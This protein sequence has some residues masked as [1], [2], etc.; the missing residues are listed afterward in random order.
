MPALPYTIVDS[1]HQHC[2]NNLGEIPLPNPGQPFFGQDGNFQGHPL[3]YTMSADGLTALDNQTGL[4]WQ[5]VPETNL[6]GKLTPDEY[7]PQFG[8]TGPV[9]PAAP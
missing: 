5:R 4:T 1:G 3:S 9:G 8:P 7:R 2:Y 6:D